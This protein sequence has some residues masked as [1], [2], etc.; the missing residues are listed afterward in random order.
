[1]SKLIIVC[2]LTGSGK[3]TFAK[4]L[5][6]Q[7]NIICLHKDSLKEDLYKSL[8]LS[9]LEHS[10]KLGEISIDLLYGLVEEQIA[11]DVDVIL[12][13]PLIFKEDYKIFE[14]W[15]KSYEV[16]VYV[17]ICGIDESQRLIRFM[18]RERHT[19][20]HDLER[21]MK[22][23]VKFDPKTYHLI[24]GKKIEITTNKPPEV[25]AKEVIRELF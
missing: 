17:L 9:T 18:S 10:K 16:E 22:A 1:M 24:P 3:T 7:L 20:H 14:Q 19:A 23:T 21:G 25:L 13:A 12:E 4:A 2:G 15:T 5:S 11:N 6:K 8:E